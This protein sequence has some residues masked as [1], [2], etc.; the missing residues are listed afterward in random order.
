MDAASPPGESRIE[1]LIEG[2][3]W[4]AGQVEAARR[5]ALAALDADVT[6][7]AAVLLTD[8]QAVQALNLKFRGK[9]KPTNVLSF[10]APD[11]PGLDDFLGD[12]AIAFETTRREAAD[13]GKAIADHLSHLVVHGILHLLGEDHETPEDAEAMEAAERAILARL[14]IADPYQ[15]TVPADG[16]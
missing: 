10:P 8:D 16:L 7:S 12:I 6:L 2:G 3:D 5:S 13:E 14:G 4:T 15:D 11:M 1:I 9:D